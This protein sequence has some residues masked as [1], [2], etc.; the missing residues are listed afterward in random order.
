MFVVKTSIHA[1]IIALVPLAAVHAVLS[2][3]AL[4]E[5]QTTPALL[6]LPSPDK[7]VLIYAAQLA[8]DAALL[9]VGHLLLRDCR[10]SSRFAY[11][12]MGGVM[13]AASYTIALRNGLM[14]SPPE[15]GSYITAGLLP[16][17]AGMMAGFLYGQ[18]AGLAP[19]AAWPK[20]SAEALNASRRFD[21]P[22]RVRTSIAA[23]AIA[24]VSP[25]ALTA[26]L[27]FAFFA[28][29][30]QAL[31]ADFAPDVEG[32]RIVLAA[33]PAQIFITALVATVV[34]SAILIIGTHHIARALR[35]TR[36]FEYAIIGALACALCSFLMAP[37]F[38]SAVFL[39]GLAAING[40]I[41]GALYRCFAGIEPVP[42]PE[43]VIVADENTLVPAEHSS[44]QGHGVVFT[45]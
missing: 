3:M 35:R 42:L 31:P 43:P 23:V 6:A 20:F 18:F 8:N 9:F 37:F 16:T 10:I 41:M 13:A 29:V 32:A 45:D 2:A 26:I 5:T 40:A 39:L 38:T 30:L 27:T 15:P 28:L 33:L 22:I 24:A 4:L 34:P 19:A 11:A 14:L 12:V 7:V 25:A 21:G 36:G 1:L 17:F 44:R